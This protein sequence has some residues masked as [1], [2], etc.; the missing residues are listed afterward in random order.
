MNIH[1]FYINRDDPALD[2]QMVAL[3]EDY[4]AAVKRVSKPLYDLYMDKWM[5]VTRCDNR[6]PWETYIWF[7]NPYSQINMPSN[8]LKEWMAVSKIDIPAIEAILGQINAGKFMD[9]V[10]VYVDPKE[11]R[12][13]HDVTLS[14]HHVEGQYIINVTKYNDCDID[15]HDAIILKKDKI[16]ELLAAVISMTVEYRRVA[17][18][19]AAAAANAPAPNPPAHYC[20]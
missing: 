12:V 13:V 7:A 5:L 17:A 20:A 16:Y 8:P 15:C 18:A 19:A 2:E 1:E 9:N 11:G 6:H 14:T 4:N 3:M 10:D